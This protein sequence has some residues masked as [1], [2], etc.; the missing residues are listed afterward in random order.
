MENNSCFICKKPV[1]ENNI[2]LD[3]RKYHYNCIEW[4]K[5]D[6]THYDREIEETQQKINS[7]RNYKYTILSSRT[8]F[9]KLFGQIP[10][11]IALI[12]KDI[13]KILEEL[14]KLKKRKELVLDERDKFLTEIYDYW[15]RRPP[16]WVSRSTALRY[17]YGY[18]QHC[19]AI[20]T[21]N[22]PLQVHHIIPVSQGGSHK[23]DNLEVICLRCHKKKHKFDI[24]GKTS[25]KPNRID[26]NL[27]LI[28]ESINNN[29][30]LSFKHRLFEKNYDQHI[31]KV[32]EVYHEGVPRIK[33]YCYLSDFERHF[34]VDKLSRI[35]LL[36]EL[37]KM[38]TPA[39][40]IK[41]ALDKD[42]MI[43]CHYT[44][45][46]GGKSLRTLKPIEYTTYKGVQVLN[47]FDF[48]T[49]EYRNFSPHR[50]KNIELVSNPKDQELISG[51]P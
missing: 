45:R 25:N 1:H 41:E 6:Q 47:C 44:K 17:S 24:E 37:P 39:D 18:C 2:L 31:V 32:I 11:S 51:T 20:K 26:K 36:S 19:G 21:Y 15:P 38:R 30:Y 7:K 5:S 14:E 10:D 27:V 9:Q 49:D 8:F 46:S 42:L 48:L 12:E 4:L 33:T 35:K 3:G 16:D 22:N 50:M 23:I 29:E 28:N 34:R 13:E 43:H 40:F